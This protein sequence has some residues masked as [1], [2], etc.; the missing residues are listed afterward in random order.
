MISML[1]IWANCTTCTL[2]HT[3]IIIKL[4]IKEKNKSIPK[5]ITKTQTSFFGGDILHI[6]RLRGTKHAFVNKFLH[7][8]CLSIN[9]YT[10]NNNNN[11]THRNA[12]LMK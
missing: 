10:N 5:L 6:R 7:F 3:Q 9:C 4:E 11:N 1:N 12:N 2:T 8:Q